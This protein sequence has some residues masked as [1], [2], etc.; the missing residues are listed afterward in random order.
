MNKKHLIGAMMLLSS[1][2]L[3]AEDYNYLTVTYNNQEESISLPT[4]LRITFDSE[5]VIVTTSE[6]N[7]KFPLTELQKMTFTATA[8]AIEALPEKAGNLEYQ[9][10]TLKVAGN[11]TLRIYNAGG[12]L[13]HMANIKEGST[14]N[15]NGLA[16]GLYIVSMGEQTIK[17]KK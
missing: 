13:I 10:G 9:N 12:A 7:T 2:T 6:G 4:I 16:P 11:G 5:N 8:T 1:A 17:I 3:L 14:V 15:L